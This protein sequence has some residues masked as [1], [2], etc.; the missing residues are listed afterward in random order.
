MTKTS[1][2]PTPRTRIAALVDQL[3]AELGP[4]QVR[5]S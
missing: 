2:E 1:L 4:T 5:V 3:L